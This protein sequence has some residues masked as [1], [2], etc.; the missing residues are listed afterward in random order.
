VTKLIVTLRNF[1]SAP[2]MKPATICKIWC[3]FRDIQN[4]LN[5]IPGKHDIEELHKT[6]TLAM[7]IYFG[8]IKLLSWEIT[9]HIPVL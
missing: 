5:D 6:G 2:E 9:L 3:D 1:E 7:R 8:K 4:H